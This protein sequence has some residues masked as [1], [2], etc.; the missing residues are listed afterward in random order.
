MK[1]MLSMTVAALL[2][3]FGAFAQTSTQTTTTETKDATVE[4]EDSKPD[5]KPAGLFIEPTV[6]YEFSEADVDLAQDVG[7]ESKFQG[8]GVGARVGGHISEIIFL[9]AD[10]RYAL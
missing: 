8:F 5:L 10:L 1:K 3:S 4:H 7:S 6:T 9:G 2:V